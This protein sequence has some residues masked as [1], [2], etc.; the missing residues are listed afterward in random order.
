MR[1]F[2]RQRSL[3]LIIA[4]VFVHLVLQPKQ[5]RAWNERTHLQ[6]VDWAYQIMKLTEH[7]RRFVPPPV[8]SGLTVVSPN[9][10]PTGCTGTCAMQWTAFMVK[11]TAARGKLAIIPFGPSLKNTDEH[12]GDITCAPVHTAVPLGDHVF[13]ALAGP[14]PKKGHTGSE[15]CAKD[16]NYEEGGI[17]DDPAFQGMG[18]QFM[19]NNLGFIAQAADARVEDWEI[20]VDVTTTVASGIGWLLTLGQTTNSGL[21][22]SV[23]LLNNVAKL[24]AVGWAI[25]FAAIVSALVAGLHGDDPF[26]QAQETT[27]FILNFE[28]ELFSYLGIDELFTKPGDAVG[29]GHFINV[30]PQIATNDGP[31]P[32]NQFDNHQGQFYDE[33]FYNLGT[34]AAPRL[35]QDPYDHY[36]VDTAFGLG[37]AIQPRRSYG[38]H[39][40]QIMSPDDGHPASKPRPYS[41][42]DGYWLT[43]EM[44]GIAF[45]PVDNLAYKGWVKFRNDSCKTAESLH[46][47]LHALGD[48]AS[49][50]HVIGATGQGHRPFEDGIDRLQTIWER[51]RHLSPAEFS[52]DAA[53]EYGGSATQRRAAF[54]LQ[55][56]QA[57]RVLEAAF[58]F[59]QMIQTYQLSHPGDIPIRDLVTQVA[60]NTLQAVKDAP[61]VKCAPQACKWQVTP[62]PNCMPTPAMKECPTTMAIDCTGPGE[63]TGFY[64]DVASN[65]TNVLKTA[66]PTDDTTPCWSSGP[67]PNNLQKC[68]IEH[69]VGFQLSRSR[70][71]G[72]DYPA[73]L[74]PGLSGTYDPAEKLATDFFKNRVKDY[75]PFA[76]IA[77][78]GTLAFL[79][80][81]ADIVPSPGS[82]PVWPPTS[83]RCS[84]TMAFCS[85]ANSCV[86]LQTDRNNCGSCGRVCSASAKCVSGA[87]Q[88]PCTSP[89]TMCGTQCVN[90]QLD[91]NNCG[92]CGVRC[93]SPAFCNNGSCVVL[94]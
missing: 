29:L 45:T 59:S 57:R 21:E 90:S 27:D 9:T 71:A 58:K 72:A 64:D 15:N 56:D 36:L 47:P 23:R 48:A 75:R 4:T 77:A 55:L 67:N 69:V 89:W 2:L 80:H 52:E 13:G 84:S 40:Y 1:A 74:A 81:A 26:E 94:Q 60:Q 17:F 85:G 50:A 19:G 8:L 88:V 92:L 66:N 39:N 35:F 51:V 42:S 79:V 87:C 3:S 53:T 78:A 10:P 16:P 12:G 82:P 22:D 34:V 54:Q 11:L 73:V 14:T 49:P 33:A 20:Y 63:C 76:E 30:Q 62:D 25:V 83:C 86:D 65:P 31:W 18:S 7:Q 44:H 28:Q 5:A 24:G 61:K 93:T 38:V 37:T 32:S 68:T 6:L 91:E 70:Y 43:T 46:W 41:A